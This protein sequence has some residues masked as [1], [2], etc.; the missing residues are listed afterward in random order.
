LLFDFVA[1]GKRAAAV[2]SEIKQRQ[3]LL[4]AVAWP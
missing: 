3:K 2:K 1:Q 4:E